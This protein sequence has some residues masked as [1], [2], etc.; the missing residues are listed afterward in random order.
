MGGGDTV[1]VTDVTILSVKVVT[2]VVVLV[3]VV[4]T[5]VF[6]ISSVD[7]TSDATP[8]VVLDE[9]SETYENKYFKK[10]I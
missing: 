8:C 9:W 10:P 7:C 6:T 4:V 2:I 5:A 3:M 1:S